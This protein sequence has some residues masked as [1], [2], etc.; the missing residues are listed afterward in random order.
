MIDFGLLN[1]VDRSELRKEASLF[2]WDHLTRDQKVAVLDAHRRFTMLAHYPYNCS[3]SPASRGA[4]AS[5][6]KFLP[7]LERETT[8]VNRAVLID[9]GRGSGKTV[10]LMRLL[11]LWSDQLLGK[12]DVDENFR[13]TVVEV[14]RRARDH[15]PPQS[16]PTPNPAPAPAPTP[17]SKLSVTQQT[18]HPIIPVGFI[19]LSL[20]ED[21]ANLLTY[22]SGYLHQVIESILET[23]GA[24]SRTGSSPWTAV[25]D[26]GTNLSQVWNHF[27]QAIA[28]ASNDQSSERKK[29]LDPEAWAL[30]LRDAEFRRRDISD[31]FYDLMNT[32]VSEFSAKFLSRGQIPMFVLAIDD[33]D[34]RPQHSV[35]LLNV[36]RQ[37]SHPRVGFVMTGD[38]PLFIRMLTDSYLGRLRTPLRALDLADNGSQEQLKDRELAARLAR[39]VYDK[40]VPRPHRY[41]LPPLDESER[42]DLM[43]RNNAQFSQLAFQ[44]EALPRVTRNPTPRRRDFI[45]ERKLVYYFDRSPSVQA[46]LPPRLREMTAFGEYLDAQPRTAIDVVTWIW[47][48][49][50]D[51]ADL[52][53][54]DQDRL[55]RVVHRK[56]GQSGLSIETFAFTSTFLPRTILP[57]RRVRDRW[58]VVLREIHSYELTFEKK[59]LPDEVTAAFMLASDIA[60]DGV[61]ADFLGRS[62]SPNEFRVP[63]VTVSYAARDFRSYD[64]AWP[65]PDW[66]G[67]IDFEIFSTRWRQVLHAAHIISGEKGDLLEWTTQATLKTMGRIAR[68][69]LGLVI[70]VADHRDEA[71]QEP[72]RTWEQ[73]AQQ[74]RSLSDVEAKRGTY[75]RNRHI[76]EWARTRVALLAAPESGLSA[77]DANTLLKALEA[78]DVLDMGGAVRGREM[79]AISGVRKQVN[80]D[81]VDFRVEALLKEID[82]NSTSRSYRW[83][84]LQRVA[85]GTRSG[86]TGTG[87]PSAE[88]SEPKA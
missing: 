38:T 67:F 19:Q 51:R 53:P 14:E 7:S 10:V 80:D 74:L 57:Q 28:H 15:Q 76:V 18:S 61:Q 43:K 23:R 44:A 8:A 33:A 22:L 72:E 62:V 6:E 30:E 63:F 35:K 75:R 69:F 82:S 40:V 39:D 34:L 37:L 2:P 83:K 4:D 16:S 36:I 47:Y 26:S 1:G 11:Q 88:R 13:D 59:F 81:S 54:H 73:L 68:L 52:E 27:L 66:D 3:P 77:D 17:A 50:V 58:S 12:S 49:A 65:L 41:A 84:T 85:T 55:K 56:R 21:S 45:E 78:A 46:A 48:R 31:R 9:G 64:F 42:V 25:E 5:V 29:T 20:I 86:G 71:A 60:A 32:L 87:T 70:D 79:R 24:R